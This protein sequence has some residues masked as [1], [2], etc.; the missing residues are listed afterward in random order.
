[1]DAE[2][3]Q[4]AAKTR[5]AR[6]YIE[7]HGLHLPNGPRKLI[8]DYVRDL[9]LN[10][11]DRRPALKI[12]ETED[13][14]KWID[15]VFGYEEGYGS[16]GWQKVVNRIEQKGEYQ[17][18]HLNNLLDTAYVDYLDDFYVDLD[19]FGALWIKRT[20]EARYKR[21]DKRE[22]QPTHGGIE[23]Y[24]E[25]HEGCWQIQYADPNNPKRIVQF[26]EHQEKYFKQRF[27][28]AV[29]VK[30]TLYGERET[31]YFHDRKPRPKVAMTPFLPRISNES[32]NSEAEASNSEASNSNAE[33]DD[34][35]S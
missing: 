5:K 16:G 35:R 1:L 34:S 8:K 18:I 3:A 28:D 9:P 32:T 29:K 4:K 7:A 26:P 33:S 10:V 22:R 25:P 19:T 27:P 31:G 14:Y 24:T 13:V 2:A 30:F 23:Y 6:N 11:Y 15:Y 21:G 12:M 17:I 20:T